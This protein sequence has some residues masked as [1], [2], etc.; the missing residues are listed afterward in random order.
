MKKILESLVGK[1][2]AVIGA[3][4]VVCFGGLL[5]LLIGLFEANEIQKF[6][7]Q[8][9]TIT[10]YLSEQV[11]TG[12]RLKRSAMIEGA[13]TAALTHDGMDIDA[14]R[15]THIEGVEVIAVAGEG[16]PDGLLDGAPPPH[17]AANVSS[18]RIGR[19]IA[20]RVP[21]A[22]GAGEERQTVGE[23]LAVWDTAPTLSA[24]RQ[25]ETYLAAAL[26]MTLLIVVTVSTVALRRM[27]ARP[28]RDMIH[29]MAAIAEEH[30]DIPMPAADTREMKEVVVSL[31]KF[32]SANEER[33][34]LQAEQ[35][36]NRETARQEREKHEEEERKR[37]AD[38]EAEQVRARE[39]A[40]A[41]AI[42]AKGL[43]QDLETALDRAK[44]GEFSSRVKMKGEEKED[45]IRALINDLMDTVD[46]GLSATIHVVNGLAKGDLASRMNGS[47][48]GVFA[49]LQSD[50]NMM[51][52]SLEIA[53]SDVAECSI[54]V[55]QNATE[56]DTAWRDLS[57]RTEAS[58]AN[59]ADTASVVEEF[60]V[61]AQ[62]AAENAN[63]AKT[64]V[65]DIR[66]QAENTSTVVER[67]VHAMESISNASHEIAESISIIDEIS[68][69]TNLLALNAGVEAA[70]AGDA[71]RGFSVVASEVRAL[72]QR[73]SEAAREIDG[74]INVST[75]HV[76]DGVALV[77]EVSL[78]LGQMSGSILQ[79][80][81][82]TQDISTGAGEQS[83]GAQ[84]ISRSL[85]GIDKA[86][87]QNAAMNE[88]V[89]AVAASLSATADRMVD[90]VQRF[91][92]SPNGSRTHGIRT[93]AVA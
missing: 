19:H 81:S 80:A 11:N 63:S 32:Q 10:A 26:G 49:H 90:L 73:C 12:T 89:V 33:H 83:A 67:T 35:E 79:I 36:A 69:Q 47:F 46:A 17:F 22:L 56:I 8:A 70:R 52:E 51:S 59:L 13:V 25:A 74:M 28:L 57:A 45:R 27:V 40:E 42:R 21:V 64:H 18:V 78:A 31:Q 1:T 62:S 92:V 44:H 15:V 48:S 50:A 5:W 85:Q 16:M 9:K 86:T 38:R 41:E 77:G 66:S 14:I 68:F 93:S 65:D 60:A 30:D 91:S 76:A 24:V 72:A 34:N 84:E 29:S 75:K 55:H 4:M 54:D 71:G 58:A 82:L 87:Q 53:I 7:N 61:S 3:V 88:E 43:M 23:L 37:L 39:T 2:N 6:E 20:V